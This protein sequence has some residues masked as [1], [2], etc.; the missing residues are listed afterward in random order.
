MALHLCHPPLHL[1]SQQQRPILPLRPNLR[2]PTMTLM[3]VPQQHPWVTKHRTR[4]LTSTTHPQHILH[5]STIT[6][7]TA[8]NFVTHWPGQ[9]LPANKTRSMPAITTI[10]TCLAIILL[11]LQCRTT[12][13]LDSTPTT[14]PRFRSPPRRVGS[15]I[16][17][18][19]QLLLPSSST[20]MLVSFLFVQIRVCHILVSDHIH[21]FF[22]PCLEVS[23]EMKSKVESVCINGREN[24]QQTTFA[25]FT[26]PGFRNNNNNN[27][28]C[29]IQ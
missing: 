27:N 2:L 15:N 7:P 26:R 6:I 1:R 20:K 11:D 19:P 12:T 5:S 8:K 9:W 13:A 28:K 10:P 25:Q 21:S 29:S 24:Y 22:D 17:R 3:T 16:S 18:A 4:V 23:K 14:I